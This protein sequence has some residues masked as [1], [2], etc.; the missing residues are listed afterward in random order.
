MEVCS[1][2]L[3]FLLAAACVSSGAFLFLESPFAILLGNLL[4]ATEVG[5]SPR[6]LF[7]VDPSFDLPVDPWVDAPVEQCDD[8]PVDLTL[9]AT[10]WSSVRVEDG[11]TELPQGDKSLSDIC[12]MILAVKLSCSAS[13]TT[14]ESIFTLVHA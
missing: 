1:Q 14:S 6:L 3:L 13:L 5:V 10:S 11:V 2:L 9:D 8:L 7:L 12:T 4:G